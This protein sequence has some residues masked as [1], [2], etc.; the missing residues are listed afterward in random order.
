MTSERSKEAAGDPETPKDASVAFAPGALHPREAPHDLFAPEQLLMI[1]DA[2]IAI[3]MTLLALDIRLPPYPEGE[4]PALK[5]QILATWPK[6]VSFFISFA[7]VARYWIVHRRCFMWIVR[8]DHILVLLQLVF[9]MFI[10]L[11]PFA[12]SVLG[13]Y[14]NQS[15]A[16]VLYAILVAL[17]GCSMT[18]LWLYAALG[19]RLVHDSLPQKVVWV[20]VGRLMIPPVVFAISIPIAIFV[21]GSWAA[22][23]WAAMALGLFALRGVVWWTERG[24][25]TESM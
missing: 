16:A 17:V 14:Q 13:E 20:F 3:A 23:S 4:A 2:V 25:G 7:V 10:C 18:V 15:A 1:S 12:T 8:T 5:D 19:K 11:T 9:L 24:K 21:S 22:L 6:L